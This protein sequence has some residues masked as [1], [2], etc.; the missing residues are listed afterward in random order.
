M[1]KIGKLYK[2]FNKGMY[3]I[4]NFN[5]FLTKYKTI[6][7]DPIYLQ[8]WLNY[9]RYKIKSTNG[10]RDLQICESPDL[11]KKHPKKFSSFYIKELNSNGQNFKKC[12][13]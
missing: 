10:F 4:L 7:D 5:Y 3:K 6:N 2:I 8:K 13:Q 12:L 1:I 9:Q 11:Y